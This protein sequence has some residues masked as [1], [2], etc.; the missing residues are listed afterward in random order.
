MNALRVAGLLV[1]LAFS[2]AATAEPI[3]DKSNH[4]QFE[5]AS[6]WSVQKV[7]SDSKDPQRVLARGE[8]S[9]GKAE[10][11][12]YR[13]NFP[14]LPAWRNKA[15]YF[16]EVLDGLKKSTDGFVLISKKRSKLGRVPVMDVRY[17]RKHDEM[18]HVSVRFV[19]FR[20][21]T[22]ILSVRSEHKL[23]RSAQA[24]ARSLKP[25]L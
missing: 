9:F 16:A 17:R 23:R 24:L 7:E 8:H 18:A 11:T 15:Y 12:L 6:G 21:L 13:I 2:A 4:Y 22:L 3:A 14:N 5:A 10:A 19:F 25:N 20:T 1:P